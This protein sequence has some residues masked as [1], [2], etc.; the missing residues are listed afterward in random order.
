MIEGLLAPLRVVLK[1]SYADWVLVAETWL[2]IM[3]AATLV[4]VGVIYGDAVATTGP[5]AAL[6]DARATDT[7][8]FVQSRAPR[9]DVG[10]LSEAV[11]RQA[12]RILGWTGGELVE[13]V[14]SETYGLPDDDGDELTDLAIIAVHEGLDRHATLRSGAWPSAGGEPMEV[15]LSVA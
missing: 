15:A 6:A 7:S 10:A 13:I 8:V 4:A 1:R 11:D 9:D 3:C 12:G 14:R 2:V 5:R